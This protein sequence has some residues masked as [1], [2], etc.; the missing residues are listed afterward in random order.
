VDLDQAVRDSVRAAE[1]E[2]R[3]KATLLNVSDAVG[4]FLRWMET[5]ISR[6]SKRTPS[7]ST[8][9]AN[10]QWLSRF[11]STYGH[12]PLCEIGTAEVQS[13]INQFPFASQRNCYGALRRLFAW[14]ITN[15]Y[16][17]ENPTRTIEPPARPA[18]RVNTPTPDQVRVLLEASDRLVAEGKWQPVQRDA[19]WLLAL[20][21]QRRAEVAA[22]DWSDIDFDK[23]EWRQ[24]AS[25]NKSRREHTVPLGP[26]ALRLL[27]G[28]WDAAGCPSTGLVLPGVRSNGSMNANLSDLQARLRKDTGVKFVLHD[29][30]RSA[31]SAMAEAGIDFAVADSLLNHEAS[32]SRGGMLKVY[33][34]AALTR[35]KRNAIEIWEALLS[36]DVPFQRKDL[37]G[38]SGRAA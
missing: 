29:L 18:P 21:A 16:V 27:G 38:S 2:R 1:E 24:P 10:G 8:I 35:F 11:R 33:Q 23:A 31:V 17:L 14:A 9:R 34:R 30:R 36:E 32:Q 12:L 20:T 19:I 7:A 5:A 13:T 37:Q 3:R 4:R 22:M 26:V 6:R 15:G 28:R 25:K